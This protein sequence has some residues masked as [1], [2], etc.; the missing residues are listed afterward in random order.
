[1]SKRVFSKGYLKNLEDFGEG[2]SQNV[3]VISYETLTPDMSL[4]CFRTTGQDGKEYYFAYLQF[5]FMYSIKHARKIIGI[6]F[7]KVI[8]FIS[9]REKQ[10]GRT[11]LEQKTARSPSYT[12]QALLARVERPKGKGYW[13]SY[14]PVMPGDD[15]NEKLES[16]NQTDKNAAKKII[17]ELMQREVPGGVV[18]RTSFLAGWEQKSSRMHMTIA[19]LDKNDTTLAM[20]LYKNIL[21]DWEVFYNRMK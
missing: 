10:K 9:P 14:I 20:H 18:D 8:E 13:A 3:T 2:L 7:S 12:G 16:L 4:L 5:D 17:L 6:S 1:M 11:E 19:D 15:I 21:G